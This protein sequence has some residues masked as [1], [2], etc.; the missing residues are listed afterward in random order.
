MKENGKRQSCCKRLMSLLMAALLLLGMCP[1]INASAA[2]VTLTFKSGATQDNFGRYLLYFEG[3]GDTA[4]KY[5]NNNTVYID[6]KEV[7]GDG[8]HYLHL[9]S[10]FALLL[11]Y[12]AIEENVTATSG[13]SGVHT[14]QI[15]SG[16]SLANGEYTVAND[17]WLKLNGYEV[18]QLTPVELTYAGSAVQDNFTR[19][20][21]TFSGFTDTA[22]KYWNGNTVYI[23]GKAVSGDGIHYLPDDGD[24]ITLYLY[25]SAITANAATADAL[26]AHTLEIPA[27]TLL[28]NYVVAKSLCFQIDG[29]SI[30][31]VYTPDITVTLNDDWRNDSGC[32]DGVWFTTSQVDALA[33][34]T[35]NWTTKY[36]MTTGGIYV[37]GSLISG[38]KL[39][40][41][42]DT[43][44][45]TAFDGCG[46]IFAAGDVVKIAGT[47]TADGYTVA[48][49]ETSFQYDGNGAWDIYTAP[50]CNNFTL[51]EN[52][53]GAWQGDLSR[54]LIWL[55]DDISG[56]KRELGMVQLLI[57]GVT[58]N[59]ATALI[60]GRYAL[61]LNADCGISALGEHTIQ[62]TAGQALGEYTAANDAVFYTHEDGSVSTTAPA[63]AEKTVTLGLDTADPGA[64]QGDQNRYLIWL[65]DDISG[66]KPQVGS[67]NVLLDNESKT[68][69]IAM[70]NGRYLMLLNENC[71][72]SGLGKHTVVI[73]KNS[74]FGEYKVTAD[75]TIYTYADGSVSAQPP[76]QI[77]EASETVTIGDDS[78]NHL[79][80]CDNCIWF[81]VS[82][83]DQLPHDL[84][85]DRCKYGASE[86][87]IY[88]N[89]EKIDVVIIKKTENLYF[90]NLASVSPVALGDVL[91]ID[92]VFGNT[93][94]AV[95]FEKQSFVYLGDGNWEIGE[96]LRDLRE[97]KYIIQDISEL[98]MGVSEFLLKPGDQ[99][100]IGD[101]C[102]STNIAIQTK[103]T[104]PA[105]MTEIK[106]GLSKING[107]WDAEKSGWQVSLL[108]AFNQVKLFHGTDSL[109][110]MTE[111][112]F[113]GGEYT[114][115]IGSVNVEEYIDGVNQ[116][117]Y[118]RKIFVKING[119]EVLS[120][121]DT[122]FNRNLGKKLYVYISNDVDE[123]KLVSLTSRGVAMRELAPTVYDYYDI[124]GFAGRTAKGDSVSC[125]GAIKA[126]SNYAVRLRMSPGSDASEL[127]L[128][129]GKVNPEQFWEIEESGW[130]LWM[131]PRSG[132]V[133]LAH[134]MDT[135][136]V[137]SAYPYADSFTVEFGVKDQIIE[138]NG[139]YV[140]TFCRILYV[141]INGEEIARWE[142][143][144]FDRTL[145]ENVLLYCAPDAETELSTLNSTAT[146]PV[147]VTVNGEKAEKTSFVQ[148]DS[149]VVPGKPSGIQV[150]VISDPYN[151]VLL[152]GVYYNGEKLDA[153]EEKDGKYIY[154]LQA[155]QQSDTLR[156]DLA[157][158]TLTVDEP[159]NTFDLFDLSGKST[160]LVQKSKIGYL[161]MMVDKNGQATVNSA[162]RYGIS[163]PAGFNH[164]P[165]TI[166]GDNPGLWGNHGAML[167]ITPGQIHFC[168]T[169][170]SSRL[171]SFSNPLFNPGSTVC[172]EFGVVKCY[173]NNI[174]KYDRW[175]V[176]AGKTEET[177]E[178]VGWY[179]SVE[180]GSYGGHAVCYGVDVGEDYYL[181]S[182]KE[183]YS[184][185]DV[186]TQE[187]Q[188]K[189]RTYTQLQHT[190]P[191]LYF[192]GRAETY[193]DAAA[194][195]NPV[196]IKF[197]TKPGTSLKKLIVDGADVTA[198]VVI[199][200]S[201][202]YCYTVS[203]L[204]K[205]IEFSYEIVQDDTKH[206]IS[207]EADD[208]LQ[209]TVSENSLITGGDVTASV[210]APVGYVPVIHMDGTDITNRLQLDENT[211]V[212][213]VRLKSI[214]ADTLLQLTSQEK[215]YEIV[216]SQQAN[217]TV[218]LG[219]DVLNG[220]LPFGGR[221]ELKLAPDNGCYIQ[222]VTVNGLAVSFNSEGI[223]VLEAVYQNADTLD[224]QAVF[225]QSDAA[226][227]Q[228]E[229]ATIPAGLWIGIGAAA[230]V[231]LGFVLLL[232]RKK[233]KEG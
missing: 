203:V 233:R 161:G 151:K 200:E 20:A 89:G 72:V 212:W 34:D 178:L 40:K 29:S 134:S 53:P 177:M 109:Q 116:G 130:Q 121:Q 50:V 33:Y 127:K 41:V 131:R 209:V 108:P 216:L 132:Q 206:S 135:W 30:T 25:Y 183:T 133:F 128:A 114:I 91:T 64:W 202:A 204:E 36:S 84:A 21:L 193:T 185:T 13:F 106:F 75:A 67:L 80:S 17:V 180:R 79:G 176:K 228:T 94:H 179:D 221:L 42:T 98:K 69:D 81:T 125:L 195:Q 159:E 153:I 107:I 35:A 225:I 174:Y 102:S 16:T 190:L 172:I 171:A 37:N 82:P 87:G 197:F 103:V 192:T 194:T 205:D 150:T 49:T 31:Q 71:G 138:K 118:C 46:I 210:T 191:E 56:E 93:D 139:K 170:T 65:T 51:D 113:S 231:V 173:E 112:E 152:N 117:I 157:A 63:P 162:I 227:E 76:V 2:E 187:N 123:C 175:Y 215:N 68:V 11:Y 146:L 39:V 182:L 66:E 122:D 101:A 78:R 198:D 149:K 184:I 148:V 222:S 48:Y 90:L 83:A 207:V 223:V 12:S 28:G 115:E 126:E 167:E 219:G 70:V 52:D 217:G 214:R 44:Y 32:T 27:G 168:H 147:D 218:T 105:N 232:S 119:E 154:T 145:G 186:S 143:T 45:Y 165:L 189:I 169:A 224:I 199:G 22:D 111:Y 3:L 110:T 60:G 129:I 26:G 188:E 226:A 73:E 164:I 211:G 5:W 140:S 23:D 74:F 137:V 58:Q 10:D 57:D 104:L 120:Y 7:S 92:G 99:T 181:Y 9:G 15:K 18:T 97:Q 156:V 43:L 1:Q 213:T 142:D 201:G 155:P 8:V 6:G 59:V 229:K 96:Y 61:I 160:M 14:L 144:N 47:V 62:I 19:F 4:D 220:K 85:A 158:K 38:A 166:L 124:S 77:P 136:E 86:G 55:T 95:R 88:F 24:N 196:Q 141:K 208:K 230:V 163:I 100:W 54:Y